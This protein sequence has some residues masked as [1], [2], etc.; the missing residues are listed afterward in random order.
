MR[1]D[2][3]LLA[4]DLCELLHRTSGFPEDQTVAK[5]LCATP[6]AVDGALAEVASRGLLP[7]LVST[8]L[9]AEDDALLGAVTMFAKSPGVRVA[10]CHEVLQVEDQDVQ[11]ALERLLIS[12]TD[13]LPTVFSQLVDQGD[14]E[15]LLNALRVTES[16]DTPTLRALAAARPTYGM[17]QLNASALHRLTSSAKQTPYDL[18][19]VPGFTPV[20]AKQPIH[21]RDLPPAQAR[22]QLAAQDLKS[23]LARAVLV[24]GGSVHPPGTPYNEALM[25]RSGLLELGIPA[26]Q[27]LVDPHARHSTTNLRNAGR[28][29]LSLGMGR[30][31]IVTGF[32]SAPFSQAFYF[33]HANLSTFNLRCQH[34]LGYSVGTLNERDAHHVEF[35]PSGD[36]TRKNYADPLD[37]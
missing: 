34:E 16:A 17:D 8:M 6:D 33:A 3:T 32:D 1:A 26:E 37:A 20:N 23:G 30:G 36:V 15:V 21:L 13:Q 11:A 4:D 31:L 12:S 24:S 9:R 27:I 19:I 10:L 25:M 22:I 7:S 2:P 29:M 35:S 18:L 14:Y 28:A 5:L